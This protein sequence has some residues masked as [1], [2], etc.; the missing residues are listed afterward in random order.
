M[1]GNSKIIKGE[2]MSASKGGATRMPRV[3]LAGSSLVAA[4]LSFG[5]M[6]LTP[7]TAAAQAVTCAPVPTSGNGTAAAVYAAGTYNPG[8]TCAYTGAGASVLTSGAVTVSADAGGDGINLTG[9]GASTV[10]WNSSAGTLTAGADTNGPVIDAST[11]SGAINIT[12]AAVTGTQISVTHGINAVSTGGGAITVTNTTGNVNINSSTAGAQQQ[13]AIRAVTTGGNGAVNI[14][15]NGTVTGRL[16]GIE[17]QSSGTGALNITANGA[18]GV[19]TTAGV[20]V[21]AIDART[22]TGALNI[23]IATGSG[24]VN[25]GTGAAILTNAGGNE[26]ITVAAGRTVSTT[27]A[28][29]GTLNLT[30]VGSTTVN[31][32]G[33]ISA[34]NASS[35]AI[36]A[37]AGSFSLTNS[38]TLSGRLSLGVTGATTV[39]NSGTWTTNGANAF[40]AGAS[41][42][43]NSGT[44]TVSGASSFTGLETFNNSG[45]LSLGANT[46][47]AAGSAFAATGSSQLQIT[48]ALDPVGTTACGAT[49]IGCLDLTGGTTSGVTTVAVT[50]ADPAAAD[51]FNPNPIV[52]V[53][54]AGG[55]S[56]D[57]D[58]VLASTSTGYADDADLGGVVGGPGLFAYALRYDAENQQHVLVS[59]PR[60]A[61]FEFAP[62]AQQVLSTWHVTA[63]A[64]TGRQ[65][66]LGEGAAG[67]GWVR[68]IGETTERDFRESFAT[69][70]QTFGLDNSYSLETGAVIAG[71]DLVKA[72]DMTVGFHLGYVQSELAFDHSQTRDK[73]TGPT[74]GLYGT[75]RS[76]PLTIDG[77]FNANLLKLEHNTVDFED[78]DTNVVSL[79]ARVEAGWKVID[80]E[81]FYVQPLVTAAYVSSQVDDVLPAGYDITFE[82]VTS[83]RA[84]VGVRAGGQWGM[85]GGW[86]VA[87]AWREFAGDSA[88]VINNTGTSTGVRL[89][90]DLGGDFQEIGAGLTLSDASG[91]WQ[92]FVSATTRFAD[93]LDNSGVSAGVRLRW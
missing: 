89:A 57:G 21:A 32:S 76:G 50:L 31:N 81:G 91:V 40:G 83:A 74:A 49:G 90:D 35:V 65:A 70:G 38:G 26:T 11:A 80:D 77:I 45:I 20:G 56:H 12:T 44:L 78:S 87:R 93:D 69:G 67:G 53:D 79:G 24:A 66:D 41:T 42:L 75:W 22:G 7:Q 19:N 8:I 43:T 54:V 46:L 28:S 88:V 39:T 85:V 16:R 5:A 33:G 72:D 63:E 52:L 60:R 10:T 55:T 25:G 48:A 14:T 84:A 18:V 34:A 27:G 64:V 47:T 61:A 71:F 73:L 13:S 59:A 82:D 4:S 30:S 3:L 29:A 2:V 36:L 23:N 9:T 17:A 15:T 62:A 58:F 86:A 1:T 6:A 51:V 68:L 92:G 37:S